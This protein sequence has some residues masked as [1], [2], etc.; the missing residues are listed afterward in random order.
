MTENVK[1]HLNQKV[2]QC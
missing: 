1:K 2:L